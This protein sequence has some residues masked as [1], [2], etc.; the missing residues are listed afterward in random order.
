MSKTIYTLNDKTSVT[1]YDDTALSNRIK[2]L[3]GKPD[4]DNQT[5]M[6]DSFSRELSI[7]NGN[8]VTLPDYMENSTAYSA[9]PT[10]AKLQDEMTK[11]IKDKHVDLGLDKLIED[12]L[13]NGRNPYVT[14]GDVPA[15]SGANFFV[16]KGDIPGTKAT[17]INKDT[18]Y[19]ANT[20]KVGDTVRDRFLERASGILEYGYWKVTAVTDTTVTVEPL[21]TERDITIG[22]PNQSLTLRDRELTISG[23]NSVTLPNDRQTLTLSGNSLSISNGNSVNLPQYVSLQDF[24]NL[25]NEYNQLKG[26]FTALLQNLKNSGAWNQTGS[27][28]FDG[29]LNDGRNIATGNINVFSKR[30]DGDLFIR[31][32]NDKSEGDLAGGVN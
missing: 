30:P 23:G 11:N 32:N 29:N 26:A 9:F 22:Q 8:S 5:I 20:I 4:K 25:K 7:S 21:G 24:N 2:A 10:Y 15:L 14:K 16:A 12:K 31:T 18:V 1:Q 6:F 19:N 17:T 3:E 28:I 27:T 13:Q